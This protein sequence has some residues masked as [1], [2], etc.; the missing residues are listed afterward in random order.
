MRLACIIAAV[1]SGAS[2]AD[3]QCPRDGAP[4]ARHGKNSAWSIDGALVYASPILKV[5]ADGA[6]NSYRLDGKGLSY[7]CDG[8]LAKEDGVRV[9]PERDPAGWQK[10]CREAWA[11][12]NETNAWDGVD[13]FG[14]LKDGSGA[15]II[16]GDGDPLPGQA[17]IT[18]TT[19][20]VKV[21]PEGTQRRFVDATAIPFIVLPGAFRTKQNVPDAALAAIWRPKTETLAYAVFA[22]TGGAL[23]EGSVRL[24]EDLKGRPYVKL[25]ADLRAKRNIDDDVVVVVFPDQTSTPQ[26]EAEAW[27][28]DIAAKG[29]AAL[30]AWGGP[31]KLKSCLH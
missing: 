2:L 14:F 7:T 1:L 9:T 11:K 6:P 13:I 28:A 3:A 25:G 8:V 30:A 27:R 12:A 16:Q 24:H 19:V 23:D 15:P 26:L 18:A 17:Y 20:E 22:D 4:I 10:K 31:D 5:D 21:A 29:Q